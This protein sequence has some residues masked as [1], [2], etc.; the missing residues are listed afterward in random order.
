MPAY[1]VWYHKVYEGVDWIPLDRF[2][3]ANRDAF[4]AADIID[5]DIRIF[6]ARFRD[7][8]V[9]FER[10]AISPGAGVL[11]PIFNTLQVDGFWTPGPPGYNS[12][13]TLSA[14]SFAAFIVPF[15]PE[16]QH[17]YRTEIALN[18][19]AEGRVYS[20]HDYEVMSVFSE[21]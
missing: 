8:D 5:I 2:V 9:V 4:Q 3:K 15:V 14:V 10:L 21:P 12:R 19:V 16:P 6:D 7:R 17:H 1:R 13:H 20:V 11:G 18:T